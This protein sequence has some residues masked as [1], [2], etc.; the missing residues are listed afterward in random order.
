MRDFLHNNWQTPLAPAIELMSL[1]EMVARIAAIRLEECQE[2][3][4]PTCGSTVDRALTPK[5]CPGCRQHRPRKLFSV[6]RN[7]YDGLDSRCKSCQRIRNKRTRS[8]RILRVI[9][10]AS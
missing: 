3:T 4:C 8:R 2:P 7:R 1:D 6:S 9:G 5:W 10:R